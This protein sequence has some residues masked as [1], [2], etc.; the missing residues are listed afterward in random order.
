MATFK[1]E[2]KLLVYVMLLARPEL[3]R[4]KSSCISFMKICLKSVGCFFK[5]L[6]LPHLVSVGNPGPHCNPGITLQN[7]SNLGYAPNP[8]YSGLTRRRF[9]PVL[10]CHLPH[11]IKMLVKSTHIFSRH[12]HTCYTASPSPHPNL[13]SAMRRTQTSCYRPNQGS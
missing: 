9:F 5:F 12:L 6:F 3:Y 1:Y 10:N 4:C 8:G 11:L 7:P 13:K 2:R